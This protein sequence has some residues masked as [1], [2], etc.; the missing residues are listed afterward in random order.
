[1]PGLTIRKEAPRDYKRI[2]EVTTEALGKERE[3]R[4]VERIQ[5]SDGYVPELSLVAELDGRIVGHAM[6]SY[7]GLAGTN[8][9]VLELALRGRV[10]FPR[11]FGES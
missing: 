7:V 5:G 2:A 11:A 4:M 8:R 9:R 6:L 10:L 1:V 3:A